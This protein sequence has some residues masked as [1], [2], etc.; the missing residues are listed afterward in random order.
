MINV[1]LLNA[2]GECKFEASGS[3]IDVTYNGEYEH[4]DRLLIQIKESGFV[5]IKIDNALA[6]SIVFLPDRTFDFEIPF[7]LERR[8]CYAPDAFSGDS[9]RI[10][11]SV[12][13]DDEIYGEREI[14]FNPHARHKVHTYYPH[15]WANFVTKEHPSLFARNAIDG[16]IQNEKHGIYPHHSWGGGAREDLEFEVRFGTD[17]L[18]SRVT[19]FIRCDFPHDTYWTE[20]DLE[21]SDGTVKHIELQAIKEG[22][23]FEFEPIKTNYVRLCGLK[24]KRLEDGSLSFAA[25]SQIQIYGKYINLRGD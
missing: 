14:S 11:C 4:K 20:A 15:A 18:V 9:H 1:K 3:Q 5:K 24:Q 2:E 8:S 22:Q 23:T 25:L 17:A 19:I 13:T 12:P 6:E 10:I 7:D 21:F 16:V